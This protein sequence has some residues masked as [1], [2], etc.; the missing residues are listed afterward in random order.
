MHVLKLNMFSKI[1][2]IKRKHACTHIHT[3]VKIVQM[4][5]KCSIRIDLN[6]QIDFRAES[7]A[8]VNLGHEHLV[9]WCVGLY[10]I[11]ACLIEN[12]FKYAAHNY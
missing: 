1:T 11:V 12:T 10:N 4:L 2:R 6:H 9:Y 5:C 3:N 8:G 7:V